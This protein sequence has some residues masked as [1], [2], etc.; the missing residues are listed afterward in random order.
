MRAPTPP[1]TRRTRRFALVAV[2]GLLLAACAPWGSPG[3]GTPGGEMPHG[4]MPMGDMHGN[5]RSSGEDQAPAPVEN[6]DEI[7]VQATEM[8]FTPAELDL[9]AGE[10]VNVTVANDGQLFH[11]FVL[12]EAGV[13]LNL[14]PG[15]Q[16]SAALTL[17]EP[18]TYQAI[19]TV[20]G[21]ADAGM[22]LTVDVH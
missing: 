21:H 18:G 3:G 6:A 17:D 4:D 2:L 7:R 1:R 15:E 16:A 12:D 22:I 10:H 11:D 14:D 20:T 5:A 8:A 9:A 19:C 13:H